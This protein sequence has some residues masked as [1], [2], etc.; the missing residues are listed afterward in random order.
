MNAVK[1]G[2]YLCSTLVGGLYVEVQQEV[3]VGESSTIRA[4]LSAARR[5]GL[6]VNTTTSQVIIWDLFGTE[7][8]NHVG[9]I[10]TGF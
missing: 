3:G 1:V 9:H 7:T 6:Q 2:L 10:D 4:E 8:A 5:V